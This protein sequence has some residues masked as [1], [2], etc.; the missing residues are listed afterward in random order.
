VSF[1]FLYFF[2]FVPKN[3]TIECHDNCTCHNLFNSLN[4][5][6][7]DNLKN[8]SESMWRTLTLMKTT[9]SHLSVTDK[10]I[11]QMFNALSSFFSHKPNN[12][13]SIR[14]LKCIRALCYFLKHE[15][16]YTALVLWNFSVFLCFLN[17]A[18]KFTMLFR[19]TLCKSKGRFSFFFHLTQHLCSY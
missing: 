11:S 8:I 18:I 9:K 4:E 17:S 14:I 10:N 16:F 6:E 5:V 1:V 7:Q 3:L 2:D 12:D 19:V 13:F 15:L